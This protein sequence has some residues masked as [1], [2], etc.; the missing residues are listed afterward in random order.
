MG[1]RLMSRCPVVTMD[2]IFFLL[3][4]RPFFD[5]AGFS[6]SVGASTIASSGTDRV[7][8]A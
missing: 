7:T 3:Y 4:R 5:F 8:V 6:R 1:V 2:K